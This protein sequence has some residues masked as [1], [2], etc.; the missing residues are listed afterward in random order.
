LRTLTTP[1][2]PPTDADPTIISLGINDWLAP[3]SQSTLSTNLQTLITNAE[4]RRRDHRDAVPD[5]CDGRRLHRPAA[6]QNG[7]IEVMYSLATSNSVPR[8]DNFAMESSYTAGNQ[9]SH[10]SD[11][12]HPSGF[13]YSLF[14]KRIADVLA[15]V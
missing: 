1:T 11:G 9:L 7:L 4:H 12:A 15:Y 3:T 6:T 10:Y 5:E 2:S 13:G 14:A 8:I